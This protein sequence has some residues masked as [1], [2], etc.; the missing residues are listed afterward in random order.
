VQLTLQTLHHVTTIPAAA[1]NRGPNGSYVF[2]VGADKKVTMKP[3]AV[4]W[5]QGDTVVIKSG[6][7]PGDTV[8]VDG[9]MILTAGSLVRVVTPAA[10]K[11]PNP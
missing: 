7:N 3:V 2:I 9:Q 1:I 11:Q 10:P 4:S 6:V 8:V 5:T